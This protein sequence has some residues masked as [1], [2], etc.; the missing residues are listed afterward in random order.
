MA[1]KSLFPFETSHRPRYF[2]N[3]F[4]KNKEVTGPDQEK[5]FTLLFA[6]QIFDPLS[7]LRGCIVPKG[8]FTS[9]FTGNDYQVSF[10]SFTLA[11]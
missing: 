5:F 1:A 11:R 7:L 4:E 9:G 2:L 6:T 10:L 3:F 8:N